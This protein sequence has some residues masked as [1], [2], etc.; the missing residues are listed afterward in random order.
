MG[1]PMDIGR[2]QRRDTPGF[3]R[4]GSHN[5]CYTCGKVGHFLRECPD[6]P[7]YHVRALTHEDVEEIMRD[8]A[9]RQDSV[10]LADAAPSEAPSAPSEAELEA[11]QGFPSG[12]E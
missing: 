6:K 3:G 10:A 9:A 7:E 12:R 5:K 1:E 2:A 8:Y 11:A 4:P